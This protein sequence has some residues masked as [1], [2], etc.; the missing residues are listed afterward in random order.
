MPVNFDALTAVQA[1]EMFGVTEKTVRNWI[2]DNGLPCSGDGRGRTVH[3]AKAIQWHHEYT[4]RKSGNAAR[5]APV[6]DSGEQS[7]SYDDALARK[8]RAEADLKELQ[9]AKERGQVAAIADVERLLSASNLAVQTQ[10]LAV[11]ARLSTQ[12]LGLEEPGR[13]VAILEAE[14]RHLLS[15]LAS[16]DAVREA[17]GVESAAEDEE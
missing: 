4:A 9:L 10:V 14:M 1:A 16:I 12:I 2:N 8:T 15:N 17:A 3:A 13:A 6:D 7:E 5:P 11:P